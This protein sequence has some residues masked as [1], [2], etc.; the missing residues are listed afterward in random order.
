MMAIG[1]Y[2]IIKDQWRDIEV[3]YYVEPEY[4]AYASQI[5]GNT[6]EMLQFYSDLLGVVYPWDKYAQVVVR[7]FVSG[8][9]ENTGAVIF[10]EF[11][12]KDTREL[13]DDNN[14]DIIAHELFHHWF[15]D[16]VT[17]ESWANLPLNESFATYGEY[18]WM[19]GVSQRV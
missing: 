3:S 19:E 13:V 18:L 17:C 4:E 12:H 15:G 6:P 9:M 2:A 16:L 14:E 11:M 10:G 8:A 7:D 5:F 1:K